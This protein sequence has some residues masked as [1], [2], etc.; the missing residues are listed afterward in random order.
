M[1]ARA[2]IVETILNVLSVGRR[3]DDIE[4]SWNRTTLYTCCNSP[5]HRLSGFLRETAKN[6]SRRYYIKLVFSSCEA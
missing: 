1:S 6:S 5:A 2:A 4:S 3:D